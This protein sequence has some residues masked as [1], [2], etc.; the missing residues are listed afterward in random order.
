MAETGISFIFRTGDSQI[1]VT[2]S[3]GGGSDT[4][5]LFVDG[6]E[7]GTIAEDATAST[8]ETTLEAMSNIVS[9]DVSVS[10]STGGPWTITFTQNYAG[11]YP[12]VSVGTTTG[13]V[14]VAITNAGLTNVTTLAGGRSNTLNRGND[15]ADVT[16]KDSSGWAENL[17]TIRTWSFDFEHAWVEADASEGDLERAFE[18][19]SQVQCLIQTPASTTYRGVGTVSNLTIDAPH[20][21]II[22]IS[23]TMTGSGALTKT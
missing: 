12:A 8:V 15:T 1:T 4:F 22:T 17:P 23:G 10:G 19:N 6:V 9:G 14:A 13:T 11:L 5:T 7:S 16:T 2:D 20:D 3:G 18:N 21:D